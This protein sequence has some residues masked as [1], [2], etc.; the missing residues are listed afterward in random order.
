MEAFQNYLKQFP[1]YHSKSFEAVLPHITI[2]H[3]KP[4]EHFLEQGQICKHIAL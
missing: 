4:G 1:H 3:L 2:K